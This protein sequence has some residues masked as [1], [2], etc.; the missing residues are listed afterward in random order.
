[1]HD[2]AVVRVRQHGRLKGP[3][4]VLSHGNGL[5]IDGYFTFWGRLLERY[6]LVLFDVRNHGRNPLGP[7]EG[8]H[9]ENFIADVETLYQAINGE[10]GG[11]RSAGVFH[12][13]SAVA[14]ASHALK[15][16][17]RFDALVLFDPPMAPPAGHPLLSLFQSGDKQRLAE[18][19]RRRPVSYQD[20]LELARQFQRRFKRWAPQAYELMARATLRNDRATGQWLLACPREYE[21]QV[22]SSESNGNLW[23]ALADCPVPFKLVCGDPEIEEAGPP[24]LIARAMARDLGLPYQAIAETT[25]F[26]QI[27][28][29]AEC[30]GTMESFL[31][32][33]G[34]AA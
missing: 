10:L 25:H 3:R 4:L 17:K 2:G 33:H 8:H 26:L 23:A 34:L 19:A 13:L 22:F 11:K 15:Y 28:R 16:G 7:I 6:E 30:I 9:W 5:A 20:P 27:E 18:R 12:S 31:A 24:A 21:A 14:A 32:E 29:P 1:M